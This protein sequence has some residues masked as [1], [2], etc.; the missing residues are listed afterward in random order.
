MDSKYFSKFLMTFATAAFLI[1]STVMAMPV[2]KVHMLQNLNETE[3]RLAKKII[4][5]NGYQLSKR[6]LFSESEKA[7]VITKA[8]GDELE[9]ASIQVEFVQ[10][11]KSDQIPKT[12]YNLKLETQDLTDVLEKIPSP[13]QLDSSPVALQ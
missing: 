13:S 12:I 9:P 11:A 7:I 1:G 10:K 6:G 4:E 8:I 5:R 3:A 2:T